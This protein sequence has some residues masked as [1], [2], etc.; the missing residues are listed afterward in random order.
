[1][2]KE[3]TEEEI[4]QIEE[5]FRKL[6][7]KQYQDSRRMFFRLVVIVLGILFVGF[8]LGIILSK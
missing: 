8:I 5:D 1:M 6:A 2:K 7:N 3:F 4:Y